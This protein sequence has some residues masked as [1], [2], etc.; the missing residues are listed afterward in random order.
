MFSSQFSCFSLNVRGLRDLSKRKAVF[1]FCKSMK[2]DVY[3]LQ[4]THSCRKDEKF[5]HNQWGSSIFFCHNSN[6]SGGVA[7]L[8]NSGFQ[9]KIVDT[10]F[11]GIGRWI[12]SVVLLDSN[13]FIM[14]NIYGFNNSSKN[15]IL[16]DDITKY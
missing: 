5:W 12:I 16:L 8:L 1:L 11:S 15:A 6:S 4:E 7:I 14:V 2:R 3:F 10:L 9:G 13:F